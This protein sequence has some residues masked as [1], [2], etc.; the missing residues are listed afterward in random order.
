MEIN[1]DKGKA[2]KALFKKFGLTGYPS[3][4]VLIPKLS[5]D[6]VMVSP[7][8]KGR[9]LTVEEFLDKIR[10]GIVLGYNKGES[11]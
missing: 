8:L 2:E 9:A 1:P 10:E 3:F 11:K 4:L 6:P 5:S 7:F